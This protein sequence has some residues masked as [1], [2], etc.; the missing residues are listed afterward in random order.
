MDNKKENNNLIDK[1][2]LFKSTFNYEPEKLNRFLVRFSSDLELQEWWVK[3]F[4]KP[5]YYFSTKSWGTILFNMRTAISSDVKNWHPYMKDSEIIK[6]FERYNDLNNEYVDFEEL[7]AT[8]RCISKIRYTNPK[9]IMIR[10]DE[11]DYAN[12][13]LKG[14]TLEMSFDDVIEFDV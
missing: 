8:G 10:F 2:K 6:N 9:F 13:D 12:N 3:S 5:T 7:D 4:K 14:Y 1:D 11:Y